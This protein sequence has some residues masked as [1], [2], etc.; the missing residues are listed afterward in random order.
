MNDCYSK[1]LRASD[2]K[3][4]ARTVY[5]SDG[6][7]IGF[8]SL[9]E[10]LSFK[11][12]GYFKSQFVCGTTRFEFDYGTGRIASRHTG[13]IEIFDGL[14]GKQVS[15]K[16][17]LEVYSRYRNLNVWQSSHWYTTG[18]RHNRKSAMRNP[19]TRGV[20]RAFAYR[21]VD[22]GEPVFTSKQRSFKV[23]SWDDIWVFTQRS[24]KD[25]RSHQHKA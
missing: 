9:L 11:S 24:W 7:L 17:A 15:A 6:E 12:Y 8:R 21:D 23:S 16:G 14:S 4:L 25:F 22:E 19:Q 20:R 3:L 13:P 10:V 18:R 1:K 5:V 2:R